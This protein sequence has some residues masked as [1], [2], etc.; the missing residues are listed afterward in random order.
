M[1][2]DPSLAGEP[3]Q[4]AGGR[5]VGQD[6][7]NG[8]VAEHEGEPLI[9]VGGIQRDVGAAGLENPEQPDNH[10]RR[11]FDAQADE[12]SRATPRRRRW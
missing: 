6:Q 10:L 3:R 5:P 9:G 11:A 4:A 12:A 8:G 1:A 7:G 2:Q